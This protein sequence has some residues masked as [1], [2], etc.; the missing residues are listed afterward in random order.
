MAALWPEDVDWR[1][2]EMAVRSK[3]RRRDQLPLQA[4]VGEALAAYLTDG[5]P[6]S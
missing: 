2:G 4:E 1:A 3:A 5:R 6:P